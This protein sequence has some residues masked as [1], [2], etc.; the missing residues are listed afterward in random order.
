M[1]TNPFTAATNSCEYNLLRW[2]SQGIVLFSLIFFC[3]NPHFAVFLCLRHM[4]K[5]CVCKCE[6]VF[7]I[8]RLIRWENSLRAHW[9]LLTTWPVNQEML[10]VNSILAHH[11]A[12]YPWVFWL[13][14]KRIRVCVLV[15]RLLFIFYNPPGAVS[16][17]ASTSARWLLDETHLGLKWKCREKRKHKD[18]REIRDNL[19]KKVTL[20]G[21]CSH[22]IGLNIKS[23]KGALRSFGELILFS[24]LNQPH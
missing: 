1:S 2:G 19:E 3:L 24:C 17:F 12:N 20:S 13:M 6:Y 4:N 11:L 10:T 14:C 5:G 22:F 23:R 18:W 15:P 7:N 16:S 9:L 21:C 8:Q